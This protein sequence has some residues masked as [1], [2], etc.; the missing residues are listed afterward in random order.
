MPPAGSGLAQTFSFTFVEPNGVTNLHVVNVLVNNF[1]DGRFGW[2]LAY[3]RSANVLDLVNG[4]GNALLPGAV[5]DGTQ[6][7]LRPCAIDIA[8][9]RWLQRGVRC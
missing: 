9:H 3:A 2:Y 7:T 4:A 1:L 6:Q 8:L 5:M